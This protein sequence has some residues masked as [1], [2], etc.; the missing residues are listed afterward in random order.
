MGR[1]ECGGAWGKRKGAFAFCSFHFPHENGE[2]V[3]LYIFSSLLL[4]SSSNS[5]CN[6]RAINTGKY[7]IHLTEHHHHHSP[8]T[9]ALYTLSSL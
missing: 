1:G 8:R 3:I 5:I 6:I 9:L 2:Q 7:S 4:T